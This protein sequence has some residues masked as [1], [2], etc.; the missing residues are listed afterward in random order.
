MRGEKS[1]AHNVAASRQHQHRQNRTTQEPPSGGAHSAPAGSARIASCWVYSLFQTRMQYLH[2][3]YGAFFKTANETPNHSTSADNANKPRNCRS[4]TSTT[5]AP[6]A[7]PALAA[8]E[9]LQRES[10]T[11]VLEYCAYQLCK[12]LCVLQ[13]C[14]Y[15]RV[16]LLCACGL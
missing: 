4:A 12:Y 8:V 9:L 1:L 16:L 10:S 3:Y 11:A 15:C 14:Y 7:V 5:R 13:Y 2:V 6:R